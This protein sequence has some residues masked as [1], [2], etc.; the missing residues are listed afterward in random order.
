[1][2]GDWAGANCNGERDGIAKSS[3]HSKPVTNGDSDANAQSVPDSESVPIAESD[4]VANAHH[5]AYGEPNTSATTGTNVRCACACRWRRNVAAEAYGVLPVRTMAKMP[6][7]A[8]LVRDYRP[9][10]ARQSEVL[11]LIADGWSPAQIAPY[12]GC[13]VH[14]VST[15]RESIKRNIGCYT[16]AAMVRWAVQHGLVSGEPPPFGG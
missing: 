13:S 2:G 9:L 14:T 10:T 16:T 4:A 11:R 5:R 12:L 6:A 7:P 1:M 3:A 8:S 15:H